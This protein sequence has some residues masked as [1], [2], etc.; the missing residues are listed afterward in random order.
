MENKRVY[1]WVSPK[2]EIKDTGKYGKGVFA[3]MDIKKDETLIV[4]GGQI[5]NTEQ[6]N[7]GGEFAANHNMDI[8][9]DFSF[10]PVKDGDLDSMPQFIVNHSC[11]PNAG[12]VEQCFMSA[13]RDIKKGEEIVY[14]YAFVM[15]SS[16]ES[17]VHFEMECKCGSSS[18]RR[19][20][21]E[22]DWKIK[23]IQEKY[24][25]YF[26]PFIRRKFNK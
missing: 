10:C 8:S 7:L 2:L 23:E 18:C 4:M 14:D 13:I 16:D 22:N 6:E 5:L 1:S 24:G 21:T 3:V 25:K 26:Q 17:L 11:E 20:V 9:E 15:W 19:R 12:F